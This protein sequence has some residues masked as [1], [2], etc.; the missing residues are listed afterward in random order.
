MDQFLPAIPLKTARVLVVGAGHMAENK[1]R[2]FRTAPCELVWR[3]LDQGTRTAPRGL[4]RP[5]ELIPGTD[6]P[7]DAFAGFRFVFIAVGNT[8][9]AA[10]LAAAARAAGALVNVVDNRSACDFY[11]PAIVDRGSVTVAV[12]TGGAAPVLARDLRSAIEG[13]IPTGLDLLGRTADGLRD[14]VRKV[15]PTVDARRR[16]WECALR[17]EAS[18]QAGKGDE[19]RTR[20]ALLKALGEF[21]NSNAPAGVV[22]LVG[23]GPGDPELLTVKAARLLRDAD[24]IVHDRLVS[25]EIL[26]RARRDALRVDVGKTRGEHPVPQDR[27]SE[28]LIEHAHA[29]RNVVRLK[30]GDSFVF[31]RGGEEVEAVRAA[32]IDV[33]VVP[34]ISAALACAASAQVPL[35]HRE[36]AQAVTFVTGQAKLDGD[37]ADYRAFAADNHTLVFYMG[38]RTAPR[39]TAKLLEAGRERST[40]VAIV[41]NGS[42]PRERVITGQLF[43]LPGI[44]RRENISGP[45]VIIVGEVA[46]NAQSNRCQVIELAAAA[47]RSAA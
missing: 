15:L 19:P 41:E 46:R 5:V 33:H 21:E 4:G 8:D 47:G 26:D 27:I 24:V 16:F 13:V 28:I 10:D 42:L 40:P 9:R 35:T 3:P 22:H 37:D 39:I 20:R 25:P 17:G 36:A 14:T 6:I 34:G 45:A 11:T 2:L 7:Y 38:V 31:G 29:G 30:G 32:G 1:L 44:I 43:D 12:S 23:A 18:F